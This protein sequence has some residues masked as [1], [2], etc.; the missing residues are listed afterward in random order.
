M[1]SL[2][3]ILP[4]V[5]LVVGQTKPHIITIVV[6]DLGKREVRRDEAG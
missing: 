1:I 4:W 5:E 2:L 6:D 3:V